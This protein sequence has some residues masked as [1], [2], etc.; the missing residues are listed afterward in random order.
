MLYPYYR[1]YQKLKRKQITSPV[2]KDGEKVKIIKDGN[3]VIIVEKGKDGK[4][5]T[6]I[7]HQPRDTVITVDKDGD[8]KV[9]APIMGFIFEPGYC[10]FYTDNKL[11]V[12][13]D[14]QWF[15]WRY[16]GFVSG[17]GVAKRN[18]KLNIRLNILS[19]SYTPSWRYMTN[20]S[21]YAG[22]NDKTDFL[23]GLRVK[24]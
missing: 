12:G 2:L 6:K 17:I 22:L 9:Y 10:G 23:A 1:D 11:W 5:K 13:I 20:T 21:F 15:Y 18:D 3:K 19:L 24:W 16:L 14:S 4:T 7:R 8:V